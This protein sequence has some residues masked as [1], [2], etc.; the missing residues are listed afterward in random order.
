MI[1]NRKNQLLLGAAGALGAIAVW[2]VLPRAGFLPIEAVPPASTVLQ[3]LGEL[4]VTSSFWENVVDTLGGWLVGLLIA[5]IIAV[6]A[7]LLMGSNQYLYRAFRVIVEFLRPIPSVALLPLVVLIFGITFEMKTSLVIF[8]T[9]WP[10]LIQAIYGVQEVDP[11]A[12]D[13]ARSFGFTKLEVFLRVTLP[14][15]T[16]NIAT[17][18]RVSAAIGLVLAI[19]AELVAG[20]DGLGKSILISQSAGDSP[21]MYALIV[22]TGIIGL[23]VFASFSSVET[24]LLKWHPSN[25]LAA[26]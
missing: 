19:T 24:R 21:T 11:V 22:A 2:E 5:A 14:S 7:G 8:G 12:R 3:R 4:T 10:I 16:A 13:T 17:G 9:V 1:F 15:A 23:A 18:L 6:P 26:V 25:R 20:V